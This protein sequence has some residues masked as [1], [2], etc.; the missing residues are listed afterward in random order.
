MRLFKLSSPVVLEIDTC[1]TAQADALG[2]LSG[3]ARK[4]PRTIAFTG[5]DMPAAYRALISII[6]LG[7]AA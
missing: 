2:G 5:G 1:T 4:G 3:F 7:A 6:H